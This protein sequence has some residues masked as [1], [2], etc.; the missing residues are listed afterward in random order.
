MLVISRLKW[1]HRNYSYFI[2]ERT[3]WN[4]EIKDWIDSNSIEFYTDGSLM[5][6]TAGAGVYEGSLSSEMKIPLGDKITGFQAEI[7]A[8]YTATNLALQKG[9]TSR[10]IYFH[11]DSQAAIRALVASR[12]TSKLVQKCIQV[13][14]R[15][16]QDIP[17]FHSI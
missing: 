3:Q 15:L 9:W 10:T 4:Q 6:R 5:D 7:Y 1:T 2:P 17:V 13:L 11:S 12:I 16:G 8:I 14:N